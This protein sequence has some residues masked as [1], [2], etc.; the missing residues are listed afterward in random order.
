MKY[1]IGGFMGTVRTTVVLDEL[2][3][4]KVRQDFGGNL[5]KGVNTLL[6]R[7]L[8]EEKKKESG[9]GMLKGKVSFKDW[10]KH[11]EELKQEEKRR[12]KLYR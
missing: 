1:D 8:F 11:H 10:E 4:A 3:V 6:H 9:F 2:V 5:S 7:H 12:D